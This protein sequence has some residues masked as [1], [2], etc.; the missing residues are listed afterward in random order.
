MA[1][2]VSTDAS[3][4][5]SE[6]VV[7]PARLGTV[8]F[9]TSGRPE[10]QPHFLR[11]MAALHS[12]WYPE[13]LSAFQA[14]LTTD[15]QFAMAWWGVAMCYNR[16]YLAGSDDAAGRQALANIRDPST[17]TPR[18]R[19]YIEA[20]RIFYKNGTSA[21]R[22]VG[23][24][25]A[26][27]KL[28]AAY[29]DDLEATALYSLSLLGYRWS[30]EEGFERQ[31]KAG[32]LAQEVYQRNPQHPGAAHYVIHS[33]DAPELAAR[34]LGAARHYAEIAPDAPHALHMP[35][36]IYLQLG[37]WPEAAASNEVAWAASESWVQRKQASPTLKDY[38][39]Y[40]WLLYAYL[41]QGRYDNAGKI[42]RGFQAMRNDIPPLALHYFDES[43]AA[44]VIDTRAWTQADQLFPRKE[45]VVERGRDSGP[46][47]AKSPPV[48]NPKPAVELCSGTSLETNRSA[49]S[50]AT[51]PAFIL[52][53][54]AAERG[55]P[56]AEERLAALR[57]AATD[58]QNNVPK[59]W[60]VRLLEITAI[61]QARAE[62]FGPALDALRQA[63]ALEEEFGKPPG[64][65][66]SYKPSHELMGEIL[67]RARRPAEAIATFRVSL[68]RHPNRAL[69]LLGLARAYSASGDVPAAKESYA[70][71]LRTWAKADTDRPELREARD[72]LA[73]PAP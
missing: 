19:A 70:Q 8:D 71:F 25:A 65:P 24:A 41:Q 12:F 44:F 46:S 51:V 1:A 49:S 35:S 62:A 29:P 39:N 73:K 54:A 55:S 50:R 23:Y 48:T 40:H 56:D 22:T 66:T 57:A 3:A 42:V 6:P 32:A 28:A 26:M 17:L 14:A 34:A 68:S 27:G 61:L 20:L 13:A 45:P 10:A 38:H 47:E 9:P 2:V 31:E 69:S 36:H 21:E 15:P 53:Y 33:Y 5:P 64:P 59:H 30:D 52:A 11:G 37:M 60:R 67:L 7:E 63:S 18:E 58:A 16:P 4:N 43:L 72:Y